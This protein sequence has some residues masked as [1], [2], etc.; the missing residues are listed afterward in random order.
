MS[1]TDWSIDQP[2]AP[3]SLSWLVSAVVHLVLFVSAA[4]AWNPA[5]RGGNDQPDRRG[6]IVLVDLSREQPDYY[7]P[8][9]AAGG[10]Q[11]TNSS[12]A[13][14]AASSDAADSAPS[15]ARASGYSARP[16][17]PANGQG[18]GPALPASDAPPVNAANVLPTAAGVSAAGAGGGGLPGGG[19]LLAGGATGTGAPRG[20]GKGTQT[21]VFGLPGVGSK[22]LYVFDRSAS[23]DGYEG[24][25]LAAAK[26]ELITSLRALES[27]HQFQ[28]VFYNNR[29][30]VFNPLA[31]QPPRLMFGEDKNKLL[32][33]DFIRGI[34]ATGG[35][36]HM[37][38]LTLALG[39]APDVLFFL[40]DADDPQLSESD[41]A[42]ITRL[43]RGTAIN[44][45]EF[46]AGPQRSANNFLVRLAKQNNGAHVYVD[47]TRLPR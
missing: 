30:S 44:A 14:D 29:T 8:E 37:Q 17:V 6:G 36:D 26:R 11:S 16:A 32:A 2:E 41:L 27:V 45:V 47:V 4:V 35:T 43:N 33:E 46:G 5:P 28:I 9:E 39:L 10:G 34:T 38:A 15:L 25:P 18:V 1:V 12:D 40:T 20:L 7:A 22:F 13:G 42:R 31:P 21:Y 24:R 19:G 3:R 23:M